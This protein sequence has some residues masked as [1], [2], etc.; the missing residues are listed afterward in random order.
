MVSP[1]LATLDL[2]LEFLSAHLDGVHA[3]T[4]QGEDKAPSIH[5]RDLRPFALRDLAPAVPV[6]RRRQPQLVCKLLRRDR[7]RHNLVRQL[8]RDRRHREP[9]LSHDSNPSP[10]SQATS[11]PDPSPTRRVLAAQTR[12]AKVATHVSREPESGR[13]LPRTLLR[14]ENSRYGET[15]DVALR[16]DRRLQRFVVDPFIEASGSD[17]DGG[18]QDKGIW[19]RSRGVEARST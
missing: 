10:F 4:A 14:H 13:P 5:P 17:T 15:K 8:D 2:R 11:F 9:P 12:S 16:F 18:G 19:R 3:G 6:D 1:E 7:G